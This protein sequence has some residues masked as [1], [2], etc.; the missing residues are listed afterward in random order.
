MARISIDRPLKE[1]TLRKYEKPTRIKGRKL[2]KKLCLCLGLLQPGDSRDVI[3]DVLYVLLRAKKRHRMMTAE[4]I[5]RSVIGARKK[6]K[7]PLIGITTQNIRRQ[8]LRLRDLQI[9]EKISTRYR[10]TEFMPLK[11]VFEERINRY[12]IADITDRIQE[13][14]SAVDSKFSDKMGK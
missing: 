11:E 1:V 4:E 12:L 7:Q 8:I 14:L 2:V 6:F 3:V 13:Y 5:T 9:V 10:I